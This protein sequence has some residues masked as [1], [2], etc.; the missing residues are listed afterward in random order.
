MVLRTPPTHTH[1]HVRFFGTV[2]IVVVVVVV[3]CC[4]V[5]LNRA[6]C[7]T[8]IFT[9]QS[10]KIANCYVHDVHIYV[11]GYMCEWLHLN[12]VITSSFFFSLFFAI[13]IHS[14]FLVVC[15]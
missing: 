3:G 7:S 10:F 12:F 5:S 13:S 4:V 2:N 6:L 9:F 11:F 1:G 8:T 15:S 14:N